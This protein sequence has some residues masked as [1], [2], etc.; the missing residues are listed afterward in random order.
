MADSHS[1]IEFNRHHNDTGIEE[2]QPGTD[3]KVLDH[4]QEHDVHD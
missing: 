4:Q 1:E 2:D 3:T